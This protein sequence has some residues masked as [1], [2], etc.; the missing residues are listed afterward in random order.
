MILVLLYDTVATIPKSFV[1]V[2]VYVYC[3]FIHLFVSC[4]R[5]RVKRKGGGD[6]CEVYCVTRV[7]WL[8]IRGVPYDPY[9]DRGGAK[10]VLTVGKCLDFGGNHRK[11]V[12]PRIWTS[13]C[14]VEYEVTPMRA[15]KKRNRAML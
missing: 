9:A 12:N 13:L 6:T 3:S 1:A 10:K 11:Q 8:C 14:I 15:R 7:V 5:C 2:V 4:P